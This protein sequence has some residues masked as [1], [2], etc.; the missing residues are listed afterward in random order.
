[1]K[2]KKLSSSLIYLNLLTIVFYICQYMAP[3][4]IMEYV[5][6]PYSSEWL[7]LA[8]GNDINFSLMPIFNIEFNTLYGFVFLCI[9]ATLLSIYKYYYAK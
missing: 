5:N 7:L 2:N 1:M 6:D 9:E 3:S 8:F 4:I